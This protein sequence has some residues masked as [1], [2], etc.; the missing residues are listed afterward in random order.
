[1]A[2][3]PPSD[4][5]ADGRRLWRD[6]DRWRLEQDMVFEPYELVLVT[7]LCRTCDRLASLRG[8]LSRLDATD[9]AFVRVASEE[10]QQ[11]TAFGRL[12]SSAG[13]PTG[14][15]DGDDKGRTAT[16]RRGQ[17]AA[18]SRVAQERGRRAS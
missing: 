8:A 17:T 2:S 7:E 1:M 15:A 5:A 3:K 12:V 10:R 14:V 18:L 16:S 9:P 11:R 13:L 4:L 6:I